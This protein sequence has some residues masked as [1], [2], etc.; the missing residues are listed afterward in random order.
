MKLNVTYQKGFTLIELLFAI[1]L[2]GIII[3]VLMTTFY[4]AL[5]SEKSLVNNIDRSENLSFLQNYI[6]DE[7]Q[8]ADYFVKSNSDI[9]MAIVNEKLIGKN[10]YKKYR[11]ITYGVIDG[12]L[13]RFAS[14]DKKNKME[15]FNFI[16]TK[17]RQKDIGAN[18]LAKNVEYIKL[19][20]SENKFEIEINLKSNKSIISVISRRSSYE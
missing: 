11:Y 4:S 18:L 1:A 5:K 2:G 12:S 20:E 10:N 17:D 19:R 6:C 8:S 13:Y 16:K 7:F 9:G 3:S 14:S 15:E